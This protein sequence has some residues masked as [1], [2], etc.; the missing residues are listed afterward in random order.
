MSVF[1]VK[2]GILYSNKTVFVHIVT[3]TPVNTSIQHY[4]AASVLRSY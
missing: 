3:A 1:D 2:I 4:L